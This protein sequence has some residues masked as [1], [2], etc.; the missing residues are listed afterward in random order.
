M[1]PVSD[2]SEVLMF[3]IEGSKGDYLRVGNLYDWITGWLK[4]GC[5]PGGGF[6]RGLKKRHYKCALT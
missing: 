3:G 5:S 2:S 1:L 6:Q 4:I